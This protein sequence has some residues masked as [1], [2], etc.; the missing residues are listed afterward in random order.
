MFIV[1]AI[2][3]SIIIMFIQDIGVFVRFVFFK[4]IGKDIEYQSLYDEDDTDMIDKQSYLNIVLGVITVGLVIKG[5]VEIL[6][7]MGYQF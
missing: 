6:I 7:K 2:I 3:V 4:L 1:K 5:V